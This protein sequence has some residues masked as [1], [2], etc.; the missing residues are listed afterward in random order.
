MG[1]EN[2]DY[3]NNDH[4]FANTRQIIP[5]GFKFRHIRHSSALCPLQQVFS[6]VG[7]FETRRFVGS[8]SLTG[9]GEIIPC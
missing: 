5:D 7:E 9:H 2:N 4:A 3:Q 1:H 8:L 6:R